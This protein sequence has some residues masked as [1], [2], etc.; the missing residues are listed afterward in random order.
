MSLVDAADLRSW[1]GGAGTVANDGAL[2]AA[3]SAAEEAVREYCGRSFE[4]TETA[5]TRRFPVNGRI[6]WI[7]DV[8]DN[9]GLTVEVRDDDTWTETDDYELYPLDGRRD[10]RPWVYTQIELSSPADQ[11]RVTALWGWSAIPE[12]VQQ[13]VKIRA[14]RLYRRKDSPEGVAGFDEFGTVRLSAR[15]DPDVMRLLKP[16]RRGLPVTVA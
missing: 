5:T 8:Y 11:I 2:T 1:V 3:H 4:K 14:H 10:G 16:Y 15:E 7:D 6:A 13:A 9:T 12:P